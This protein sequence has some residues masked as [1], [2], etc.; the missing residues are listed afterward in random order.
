MKY[1]ELAGLSPGVAA[2]LTALFAAVVPSPV[3]L[4]VYDRD[5]I[6]PT[7][8]EAPYLVADPV[9]ALVPSWDPNPLMPDG[10]SGWG[11]VQ[12]TAVGRGRTDA[13]WALD[14]ARGFLS[15]VDPSTITISAET[16]AASFVKAVSSQ[17]PPTEPIVTG[18]LVTVTER[19]NFYV[20][21]H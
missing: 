3:P 1:V 17:G 9:Q 12:L 10:V 21:A 14:M 11:G 20:E 18:T 6:P 15:D 13:L 8:D 2:R 19:F 16:P 5:K 4:V 7:A